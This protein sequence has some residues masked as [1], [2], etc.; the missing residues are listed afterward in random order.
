MYNVVSGYDE[1][2]NG[3]EDN[4]DYEFEKG[5]TAHVEDMYN[6]NKGEKNIYYYYERYIKPRKKKVG[7]DY[8]NY[9]EG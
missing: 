3:N 8:N 9:Y 7:I 4:Y 6:N 1:Y 2:Y 5:E